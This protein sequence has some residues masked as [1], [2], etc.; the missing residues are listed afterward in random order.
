MLI[1]YTTLQFVDQVGSNFLFRGGSPIY[2]QDPPKPY[3]SY[4]YDYAG[5]K[6]ALQKAHPAL[7][8]AFYL[9][10]VSLLYDD[11]GN[12]GK[13][14]VAERQFFSDNPAAGQLVS[15]PIWGTP[16]CYFQIRQKGATECDRLVRTLEDWLP[17]RLIRRTEMLRNMLETSWLPQVTPYDAQNNLPPCVF[18]VHCD[19][20]CDRTGEVIGAYRLRTGYSWSKMWSEQPCQFNTKSRPMGCNN[21]RALQWYAYWLNLTLGFNLTGMGDETG[22]CFDWPPNK[23]PKIWNPCSA[24]VQS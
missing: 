17:D 24:L 23:Q 1:D 20:G 16:R 10:D 12:D 11:Q 7:P 19:G 2:H 22:A 4:M 6:D 3:N 5:L 18:Y 21:Y 13:E 15:W 8:S 14:L 9:V